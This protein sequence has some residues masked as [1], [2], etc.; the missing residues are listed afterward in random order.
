VVIGK[1]T[2]LFLIVD[3]KFILIVRLVEFDSEEDVRLF[4]E[5]GGRRG[6]GDGIES[7]VQG[8]EDSYGN[9]VLN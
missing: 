5:R 9:S 7:T 3:R 1:L 4:V 8:Q 6:N 2:L